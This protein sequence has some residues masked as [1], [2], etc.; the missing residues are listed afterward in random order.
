MLG[1]YWRPRKVGAW[2]TMVHPEPELDHALLQS[3]RTSL[4]YLTAPELGFAAARRLGAD[5]LPAL[6]EYQSI[7]L[8]RK[9]GGLSFI[10]ALIESLGDSSPLEPSTDRDRESLANR[11]DW[12][13]FIETT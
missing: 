2:F 5:A 6:H 3:L 10:T 9:F 4:G 1:T 11:G 7:A 8:E 13:D 12:A